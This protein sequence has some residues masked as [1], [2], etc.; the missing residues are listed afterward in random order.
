MYAEALNV[1]LNSC[2]FNSPLKKAKKINIGQWFGKA[3]YLVPIFQK[4]LK[5]DLNE[6]DTLVLVMS[7]L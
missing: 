4:Y 7:T 5:Y 6:S 1:Q 3:A 2:N